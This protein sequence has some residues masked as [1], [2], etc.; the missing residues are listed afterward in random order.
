MGHNYSQNRSENTIFEKVIHRG[1]QEANEDE[2]CSGRDSINPAQ[3]ISH[4][5]DILPGIRVLKSLVHPKNRGNQFQESPA[6][7]PILIN[8]SGST[9]N[10]RSSER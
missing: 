2:K 7:G 3:M 1:I 10:V 9:P 6:K 5:S 4:R 8:F